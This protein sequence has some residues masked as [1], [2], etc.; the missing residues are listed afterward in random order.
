MLLVADVYLDMEGGPD[1]KMLL[2]SRYIFILMEWEITGMLVM[3][4]YPGKPRQS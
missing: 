1:R 2:E 4:K 3:V